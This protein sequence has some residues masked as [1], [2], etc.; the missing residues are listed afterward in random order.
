M[1]TVKD[2]RS[3]S[4]LLWLQCS[5]PHRNVVKNNS[6]TLKPTQT[7]GKSNFAARSAFVPGTV[8]SNI[9]SFVQ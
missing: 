7:K 8:G 4:R 3:N 2:L 9:H 5:T 1:E 6:P